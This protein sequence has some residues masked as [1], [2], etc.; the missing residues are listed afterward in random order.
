MTE[1][2]YEPE[3]SEELVRVAE[4]FNMDPEAVEKLQAIPAGHFSHGLEQLISDTADGRSI[5]FADEL[6]VIDTSSASS[7][8]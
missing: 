5:R 8:S 3:A 6:N 1:S 4:H 7:D 2:P